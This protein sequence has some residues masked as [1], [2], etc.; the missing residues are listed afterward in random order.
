MRIRAVR[1][2]VLT[3]LIAS[4][5]CEQPVD[6]LHPQY[7]LWSVGPPGTVSNLAVAGV[8]DTS[9]ELSFMDVNDGTDQPASYD[10]RYA[11]DTISWASAPAVT[12]GS[13]ATPV[14]GSA[15]GA[16]RTC[17]VLGLSPATHYEFQLVPFHGVLNSDTT[18]FGPLSNVASATTLAVPPQSPGTVPDLAVSTVTDTAVVLFFTEVSDGAGQPASYDIR[19]AVGTLDWGAA[20]AVTRGSCT[21]PVAGSAIGAKRTCTVLGLAPS[22]GYQFQLVPFR[23]VLNTASTVF[24]PLSN[25]ASGTTVALVASV[26]VSLPVAG[27]AVGQTLQLTATPKDSSG[28]PLSGRTIAWSSSAQ[29]VATVSASGL[30]TGVAAGSATITAMSEGKSGTAAI[31]VTAPVITTPGPVRDLAVA[32]VTDTSVA[33]SFTEVSDGAGQP[34]GYDIRYAVGTM[35]WG[36]APAVTRGSCTSPVAGSAIGAKRTCTVLGLASSTAYQFQ[37]VPFRGVLNTASTVFGSLSSVASGT[38]A[39]VPPSVPPPPPPPPP[40]PLPPPPPPP[41]SAGVVFESNWTTALGATDDAIRDGGRWDGWADWGGAQLLSVVAGGP[42]GYANALRV[43]Q[44]G[45]NYA[46]RVQRN[47]FV[48]PSQ[49]FYIRFY[50]RNDD[51]SSTEDHIVSTIAPPDQAD[52]IYVTKSGGASSWSFRIRAWS[53]AYTYPISSWA[54]SRALTN[55]QWY[56]LEFYVHFTDATHVQVHPRVY[57]ATGALYLSDADFRQEDYGAATW[58]GR[59]DWTLASFA[60]AGYSTCLADPVRLTYFSMGNNGQAGSSDTGRYWYY[61]GLQVRTDTWPGP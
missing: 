50:M 45:P 20:P 60:A 5:A 43:Q 19:Y 26:A 53:C 3:A 28:N 41:L 14:A 8:T 61:A 56:R 7:L 57:D 38:T 9:V 1:A 34:A 25:V 49:D 58:N 40:P 48:T 36:A 16:Q 22:T 52:L 21:T 59:S 39:A 54:P 31:T 12:Q 30:V 23:G 10:I 18:V 32:S 51:V 15:I 44:R 37:L 11:A 6:P 55:G 29:Q 33:L 13:C 17:S 27:A 42:T 46:A 2:V 47:A 35:D 24:G 4:V